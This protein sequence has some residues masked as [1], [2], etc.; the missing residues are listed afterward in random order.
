[1][2][3]SDLGTPSLT[4]R[5]FGVLLRQLPRE[6]RTTRATADDP[7]ALLWT[8]EMHLQ[9]GI[10]DA[11]VAGNWQRGGGKGKRP[12]PLARPGFEGNGT[13]DK[14]FGTA[15]T[16]DELNRRLH[17]ERYDDSGTELILPI[18][19]TDHQEPDDQ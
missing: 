3:L 17:P 19:Y 9:A 16:I 7:V 15:V 2:R 13:T 1:M 4:W 8:P 10:F 5:R 6:A 18:S 11:T 14:H 12:K